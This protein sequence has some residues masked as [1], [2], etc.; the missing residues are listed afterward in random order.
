MISS[1]NGL[2]AVTRNRPTWSDDGRAERKNMDR[3]SK[4]AIYGRL[5]NVLELMNEEVP[6][7]TEQK[8][9]FIGY[10]AGELDA[11]TDEEA[12]AIYNNFCCTE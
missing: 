8:M 11:T 10:M 7:T 2:R 6:M 9:T 3:S 5:V 4:L 12:I 1:R